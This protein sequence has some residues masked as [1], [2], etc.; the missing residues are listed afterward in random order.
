MAKN[1]KLRRPGR[2]GKAPG[3]MPGIARG[4]LILPALAALAVLWGCGPADLG[5]RAARIT[6]GEVILNCGSDPKTLDPSRSEDT[7]SA[8]AISIMMRGLCYHDV[9]GRATPD[10]AERWTISEDGLTYDFFLR[11]SLWTNGESVTAGDFVHAWINRM[12]NPEFGSTYAYILFYI[13]GAEA[14]YNGE[15]TDPADVGVEAVAPDHLRVRLAAPAPFFPQLTSHHAYYPVCTSVDLADPRWPLK[16]ESY[17]GNGPFRMT[18]YSPGNKL[19]AVKHE[20]YWN[21]AAVAMNQITF[22][23]IDEESTELIAFE[24]GELDGTYEAPRPDL[25]VLRATGNLRIASQLATYFL[26]INMKREAFADVR[27]RRALT[28]AIDR[29]SIV[30]YIARAGEEPAFSLVPP[31]LYAEPRPPDFADAD[32]DEAR[33]LLAEA[34]YPGGRG[35]P[36]I[37]YLYNT[38]EKH[39]D[40]AQV[41][42]E[43]WKRELGIEVEIENQEFKVV[44]ERRKAADFDIGRAGWVADFS[45]PIN[46]LEMFHSDSG[47]NDSHLDDAAY[48][49][50]IRRAQAEAD[51][52]TRVALLLEAEDRLM[53]LMP[54]IPIY[55][56]KDPYL[57]APGLEGYEQSVL[58]T[59][60]VTR[61]RWAETE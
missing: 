3:V 10:M 59:I 51:P 26:N 54:I 41:I 17:V 2:F 48:D 15:L 37:G 1:P 53:E 52:E 21:S 42:Q 11:D 20:G 12:L 60:D 36:K 39:R 18:V 33:R 49:D 7:T 31:Q 13:D 47:N 5:G 29:R 6:R 16:A 25:E 24:N 14:Y 9:E 19:I 46:F 34:G 43:S 4:V 61:L 22:R 8:R 23:F 45:D 28:L 58:K 38:N 56:Y 44:I 27:V 40:I 32:F 57:S 50:L 30:D 55:F 35:F